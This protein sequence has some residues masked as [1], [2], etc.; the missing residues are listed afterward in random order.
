MRIAANKENLLTF[1]KISVILLTAL[2]D[3]AV[4]VRLQL[5]RQAFNVSHL[6]RCG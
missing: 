3:S 5:N 4:N 2:S 6:A 1:R